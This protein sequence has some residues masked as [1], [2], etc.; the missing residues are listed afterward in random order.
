MPDDAQVCPQCA[1]PV[2]NVPV[3]APAP[4]QAAPPPASAWLNVPPGQPQYQQAQYMPPQGFD[5]G[6]TDGKAIA[7]LVLGIT[8]IV[9]CLTFLT[10]IPAIILGHMSRASIRRSMGR[11]KGDGLALAGLI[12]GYISL[13]SVLI[14]VAMVIPNVMRARIGA[15][16]S[17]ARN[18]LRTINTAQVTYST[19]YPERGYAKDL[20]T[21]GPGQSGSCANSAGTADHACLIDNV[22]GNYTCTAGQW[23]VKGEYK[24]TLVSEGRC[25]TAARSSDENDCNYMVV[26][27][28]L[29]QSAGRKS[30]CSTSDAVVRQRY[31]PVDMPITAEGCASWTPIQ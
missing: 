17:A 4:Q 25:G 8:S 23:C 1:T 2:Q 19:S 26:A 10:G 9:L 14:L 7:S 31:G 15:N 18:T 30:F 29:G 3:P 5:Q 6:S 20:A 11:L 13:P 24:Y 16:E 21:L 27:T 28:P 12:L 22:L